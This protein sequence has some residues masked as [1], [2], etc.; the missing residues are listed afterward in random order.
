MGLRLMVEHG[1]ASNSL[2]LQLTLFR[3]GTSWVTI[4]IL[5]AVLGGTLGIIVV[6]VSASDV[7]GCKHTKKLD[8]L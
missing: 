4:N 2:M 1:W 6:S 3:F 7:S 5:L 8:I